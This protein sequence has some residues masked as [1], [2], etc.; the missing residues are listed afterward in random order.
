MIK[1]FLQFINESMDIKT[2]FIKDLSKN[3]IHKLRT[4]SFEESPEYTVF[5]GMHFNSPFNF[6]L[7]LNVRFDSNLETKNDNHFK[8]LS[9]EEL[10]YLKLG[11]SIDANTH[12]SKSKSKL[13]KIVLHIVINPKKEP[14]LYNNLYYRFI[15]ILT[16]E[17]NHL[18]QLGLNREPFNTQVSHIDTRNGSKKSYKYFL[19]PDE[20][21]SM[22]EGMYAR[23]KEQDRFL[24]DIFNDYLTPFIESGYISQPEYQKVI[25]TWITRALELYPDAK[26]SKKANQIISNI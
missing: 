7:I 15:D 23:S 10:N 8:N 2:Q 17:T 1:T 24:D 22:V 5:S 12:M 26:F 19:L 18:N 21:E 25:K 3:L 16:H 4:S 11:Y 20:I 6:D 13:P 9:W 14:S